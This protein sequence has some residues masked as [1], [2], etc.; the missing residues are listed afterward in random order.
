MLHLSFETFMFTLHFLV[1]LSSKLKSFDCLCRERKNSEEQEVEL[2]MGWGLCR[3]LGRV[4]ETP[5][6]DVHLNFGQNNCVQAEI[7][8][9]KSLGNCNHPHFLGMGDS[10]RVVG[11]IAESRGDPLNQEDFL[12][13]RSFEPHQTKSAAPSHHVLVLILGTVHC[14]RAGM[15]E[16][17][18]RDLR[19]SKHL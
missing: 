6:C 14:P 7:L 4:A 10:F 5:R 15:Q 2:W 13:F 16:Q 8:S 19:P 12:C 9:L 18:S 3:A 17:H 11:M 1:L